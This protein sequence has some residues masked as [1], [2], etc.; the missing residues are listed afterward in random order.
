MKL[1]ALLAPTTF[2][3]DVLSFK[4]KIPGT[5]STKYTDFLFNS[6]IHFCVSKSY[7]R[8]GLFQDQDLIMAYKTVLDRTR[9]NTFFFGGGFAVKYQESLRDSESL[10]QL[11]SYQ[12][13]D[14][15]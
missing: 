6:C 12:V 1:Q 3:F 8:S 15:H 11:L 10:G 7:V 14:S 5:F 13:Y 2:G 9:H 4:H